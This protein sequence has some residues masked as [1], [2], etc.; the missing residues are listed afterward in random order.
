MHNSTNNISD[1]VVKNLSK[2]ASCRQIKKFREALNNLSPDHRQDCCYII[3]INGN[4][5]A[6]SQI[7][8]FNAKYQA[9]SA[10]HD[11]LAKNLGFAFN[12]LN[13]IHPQST[14]FKTLF[15][16]LDRC[17]NEY[18]QHVKAKSQGSKAMYGIINV[19]EKEEALSIFYL[20]LQENKEFAFNTL[21]CIPPQSTL[22]KTLFG[23]L[24]RYKN[25]YIQRV[26]AKSQGSITMFGKLNALEKK[27]ALSIFHQLLQ[28]KQEFAF[29]IL[30]VINPT[31]KLL[32][33][34]FY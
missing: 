16:V 3:V 30:D 13:V 17:K 24:D 28:E 18:I 22:F 21:D 25:E 6:M 23:R 15:S 19:V 7:L 9:V 8:M 4:A 2:L 5:V 14:L 26:K 33:T 31:H 20:L 11:L 1:E 32:K 12:T 27:E 34:L 10:F 29:N